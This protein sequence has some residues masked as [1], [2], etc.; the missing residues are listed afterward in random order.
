MKRRHPV[1]KAR[2]ASAFRKKV[3]KTKMPNVAAVQRGGIRL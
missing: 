3:G 2:S 1:N